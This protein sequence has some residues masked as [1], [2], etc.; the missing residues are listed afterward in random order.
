MIVSVVPN[1]QMK[2]VPESGLKHLV[3]SVLAKAGV[4][5]FSCDAV[6]HSLVDANLRGIDT[7]G[8]RLLPLYVNALEQGGI[9]KEPHME[10]KRTFPSCCVVDAD[11]GLGAA[12]G[13][14]AID[15]RMK[16]AEEQGMAIATVVN[17]SHC[18]Y[19][20]AFSLRAAEKGFMAFGFTNNGPI[21]LSYNGMA[22]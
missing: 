21:M 13:F 2:K 5:P 9:N 20:A 10:I 4:D 11:D 17:S 12:A 8:V 3:L 1:H 16:I 6:A 15:E 14:R 7:H 22:E 18:G 19:M